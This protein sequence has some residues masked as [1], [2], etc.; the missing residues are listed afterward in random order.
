MAR[1]G[2]GIIGGGYMGKLHAAA[3]RAVA[4]VF[5]TDLRP[6]LVAVCA[7]TPESAERYRARYG[8]QSATP[9]WRDVIA[10]PSV[11]AV[12]VA[13]PQETHAEITLAAI[14]AGKHVLCEK[15]L[16][17]TVDECVAMT[18]AALAAGI[19][20][21]TGF[22]YIKT[23]AT[24]HAL[25]LVKDG[26]IG[27][28]TWFRG[29]HTEDFYADPDAAATWRT[30]GRAN[31]TMGDLSPHM[32]QCAL[33]FMGP[34]A[35]VSAAI[36]TVHAERPDGAGGRRPVTNDD[37]AHMMCRFAG[38]QTGHL[39]FSRI[40]TG[41]KMGYAYELFGT[42]GAIRFN[43]EDQNALWLYQSDGAAANRGFTKILAGPAHPDYWAFCQ[44]PGHGTG[45][46]D[47]I[48]IEVAHFLKAIAAGTFAWP[49]FRVGLAVQQVVDAAWTSSETGHWQTVAGHDATPS[50][51]SSA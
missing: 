49:D 36:D 18:D 3:F 22:N 50:K 9:D 6:E 2:I 28:V 35:S 10:N 4:T 30:E 34:I 48:I 15:P 14:A 38:G 19:T 29:E 31:G 43:Q 32:I 25:S 23:P 33:A 8:F 7:S 26:A 39:M 17:V 11:D 27:D 44:G 42:K 16:A 45:Y 13:S 12:V 20:H 1:V 37:I 51:A 24:Q 41:R 46:L 21:M 5:E 47:Q 40:A